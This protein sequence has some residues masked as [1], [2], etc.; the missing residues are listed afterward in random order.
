MLSKNKADV[1]LSGLELVGVLERHE[2]TPG[3][4]YYMKLLRS[5]RLQLPLGS[6]GQ[7]SPFQNCMVK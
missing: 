5:E 1:F 2:E 6:P 3:T 4:S 7:L